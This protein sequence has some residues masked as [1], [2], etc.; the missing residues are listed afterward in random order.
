MILLYN[1]SWPHEYYGLRILRH[2][3]YKGLIKQLDYKRLRNLVSTKIDEVRQMP[4]VK[5]NYKQVLISN[6]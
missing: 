3:S 2:G 5:W 4:K 6:K 1:R